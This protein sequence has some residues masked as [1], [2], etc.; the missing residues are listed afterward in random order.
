MFMLLG[1]CSVIFPSKNRDTTNFTKHVLLRTP[2]NALLL[3]VE[4]IKVVCGNNHIGGG[5]GGGGGG[6]EVTYSL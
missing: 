1:M 4:S 3:G 2:K 6:V 5:G